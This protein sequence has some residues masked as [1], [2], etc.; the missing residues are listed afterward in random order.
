MRVKGDDV[1]ETVTFAVKRIHLV[2]VFASLFEDFVFSYWESSSQTCIFSFFKKERKS[3]FYR[4]N[5]GHM[6]DVLSPQFLCSLAGSWQCARFYVDHHI[7]TL[8]LK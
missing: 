5:Q 1:Y 4:Q 6:L 2:A 8:D 7:P 3:S